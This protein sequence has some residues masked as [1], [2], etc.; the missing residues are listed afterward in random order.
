[1]PAV[2]RFTGRT[3]VVTGGAGG[4]GREVCAA[5]AAQGAAVAVV[6]VSREAVDAVV[7]SL[8][9]DGAQVR[10]HVVDVRD[11]GAVAALMQSVHDELGGPHLLVTLAG[12][13]LGT[14]RDLPDIT[15]EHVDLVI[16]V[17]VKGTLYCAQAAVPF[18]AEAGGGAI[19]TTSSIGGRQPSPV[20]GVPYAT[21][22]AAVVG[23]TKRLA[24][25]VGPQGIRVNAIAPGLFLT[26]RLQGMY[27]AM[28]ESERRQVLDAIPL[29]RF[30]SISEAVDP[31][32]FLASDEASY[33][34]GVVLD[35]NG[36]RFMPP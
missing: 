7:A 19:V 17:N 21:S 28:P 33:I 12:G 23:L 8:Q 20:T 18:M 22:K 31:I 32:L 26:G 34:T 1:M 25:E 16:D 10:G 15:P 6:D 27:D 35:V 29:D 4:I 30:P 14:P 11:A 24:R 5:F 9:A 36:G 13:S 2:L 3:A